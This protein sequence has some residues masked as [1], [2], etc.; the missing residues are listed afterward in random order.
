MKPENRRHL[1]VSLAELAGVARGLDRAQR[2]SMGE[3]WA[4][5]GRPPK[6]PGVVYVTSPR[7]IAR[8][9]NADTPWT[10]LEL[11][12]AVA[13]ALREAARSLEAAG[14]RNRELAAKVEGDRWAPAR[15]RRSEESLALARE[16]KA[17]RDQG[18][19]W[20]EVAHKID[21]TEGR[22]QKM[23]R[24]LSERDRLPSE[25]DA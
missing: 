16:A 23:V 22:A 19:T 6:P 2:T 12:G 8:R 21:R 25:N 14:I 15:R 20:R 10:E 18:M 17:Y 9:A 11:V 4:D 13:Y 1:L 3:Q 5:V 24:S 7:S